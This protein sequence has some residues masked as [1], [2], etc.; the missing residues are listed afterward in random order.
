MS[1]VKGCV[2]PVHAPGWMCRLEE[3]QKQNEEDSS[4][5]PLSVSLSVHV[6]GDDG[7]EA[8]G[9]RVP[10]SALVRSSDCG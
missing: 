4:P 1:D 3:R 10:R 7:D 6:C 8:G 5:S 9:G 2:V